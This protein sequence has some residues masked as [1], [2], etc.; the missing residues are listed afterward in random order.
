[1]C[2]IICITEFSIPEYS[3]VCY[4]GQHK[5]ESLWFNRYLGSG[6]LISQD[7]LSL[8]E[9]WSHSRSRVTKSSRVGM[10]SITNGGTNRLVQFEDEIPDSWCRGMTR[11]VQV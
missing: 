8:Y 5:C 4:T 2:G 7:D 6:N 10:I 11:R 3:M 9:E 1:M